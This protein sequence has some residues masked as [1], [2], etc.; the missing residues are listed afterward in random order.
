[1]TKVHG[2]L[3]VKNEE[4][5]YLAEFIN[6]HEHIFDS[7]FAYDDHSTDRTVSL[8]RSKGVTVAHRDGPSFI[9]HE[10]KFRYNAWLAFEEAMNPSPKD[11]VFVIDADEFLVAEHGDERNTLLST[12]ELA[13]Y[14]GYI[15][16]KMK[17]DEVWQINNS[18]C[19]L[20]KDGLWDKIK[21]S[22]LFKYQPNARWNMKAMGCGSA[23]TYTRTQP[24]QTK[25]INLLHFGYA[26]EEDRKEKFDR[27]ANLKDHGH[28][29]N[30][31][32]SI[33]RKP[34]LKPYTGHL[35]DWV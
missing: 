23:P 24:F 8:C 1:M 31:I 12:I 6:H 20:R 21:I 35:P 22:H 2:L 33:V 34:V 7:I 32:M 5:R 16:V 26:N 14:F 17:K 19:Y 15:V 13:E 25:N 29:P 30:H 10:G 11:W 18:S 9:E 28:N 4:H 27:Y 3:V